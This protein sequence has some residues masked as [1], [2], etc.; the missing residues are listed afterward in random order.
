MD[1]GAADPQY[2]P[3]TR[4]AALLLALLLPACSATP[5]SLGLTGPQGEAPA[6]PSFSDRTGDSTNG[7]L[8]TPTTGTFY[9]PNNGPTSGGSGYY[10]YN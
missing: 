2:S 6:A 7:P 9:G 8:G 5:Q 1:N 4:I 3:M 10:G